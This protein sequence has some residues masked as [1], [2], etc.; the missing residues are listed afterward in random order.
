PWQQRLRFW[1]SLVCGLAS[2]LASLVDILYRG[3]KWSHDGCGCAHKFCQGRVPGIRNPDAS[4]AIDRQPG[5]RAQAAAAVAGAGRERRPVI[6]EVGECAVGIG[7]PNRTVPGDCNRRG[8]R[9]AATGKCLTTAAR[10]VEHRHG[11]VAARPDIAEA[12]D[13]EAGTATGIAAGRRESYTP[14]ADLRQGLI[15]IRKPDE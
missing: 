13:R 1:F 10:L 12:V 9:D 2:W 4:R 3:C 11:A 8:D 6:G 15:A 14:C 7:D 5:R